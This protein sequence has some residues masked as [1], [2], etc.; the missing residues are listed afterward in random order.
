[1]DNR[2]ISPII[3]ASLCLG[4]L[5]GYAFTIANHTLDGFSIA[6]VIIV[7]VIGIGATLIALC[8]AITEKK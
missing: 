5:I 4:S 2:W 8:E 3:I 6:V 7:S 1:M